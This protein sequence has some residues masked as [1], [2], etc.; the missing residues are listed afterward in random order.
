MPI[1]NTMRNEVGVILFLDDDR[2]H[3]HRALMRK[4]PAG[5]FIYFA[6]LVTLINESPVD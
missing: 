4:Y 2:R 3:V 5:I 6:P 1:H